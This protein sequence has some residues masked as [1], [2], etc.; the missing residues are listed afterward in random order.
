MVPVDR[1]IDLKFIGYSRT[2]KSMKR[3][4]EEADIEK[5]L[6]QID[7]IIAPIL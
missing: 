2:L 4:L 3:A 5:V 1:E 7:T 6:K